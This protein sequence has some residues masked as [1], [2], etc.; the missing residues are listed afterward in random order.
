MIELSEKYQNDRRILKCDYIRYSPSEIRTIN[1]PSSQKY[2]NIPKKDS[3]FSLLNN[4]IDLN[5]AV[6]YAATGI[7]CD[8]SYDIKLVDLGPIVL[9]NDYKLTTGSGKHL[10]EINLAHSVFLMYK[11][12]TSV[13]ENDYLSIGFDR[14]RDRRRREN[15]ANKNIKGKYHLRLF[16]EFFLVLLN[17]RKQQFMVSVTN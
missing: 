5:I 12:L 17:T 6:L 8:D 3:V 14:S 2:T 4:Y 10:D 7:R 1:S 15:N 11:L 13:K 16:E 9:F